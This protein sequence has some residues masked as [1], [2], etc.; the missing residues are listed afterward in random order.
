ME[1]AIKLITLLAKNTDSYPIRRILPILED[2]CMGHKATQKKIHL[3]MNHQIAYNY[4]SE[5]GTKVRHSSIGKF[6]A[7]EFSTR[8]LVYDKYTKIELATILLKAA[9]IILRKDFKVSTK[10]GL[11]LAQVYRRGVGGSTCMTGA[12]SK[13]FMQLLIKNPRHV[14]VII[15]GASNF[16]PCRALLWKTK[17]KT[18]ILDRVYPGFDTCS[19]ALRLYALKQNWAI[20]KSFDPLELYYE[21]GLSNNKEENISLL[22]PKGVTL[23]RYM[24]PEFYVPYL[25]TFTYGREIKV[26]KRSRLLLSNYYRERPAKKPSEYAFISASGG[27]KRLL[28]SIEY[29]PPVA[30]SE[31]V[32]EP[33]QEY[34]LLNSCRRQQISNRDMGI[35]TYSYSRVELS[36]AALSMSDIR[37]TSRSQL[38]IMLVMRWSLDCNCSK[39]REY[40]ARAIRLQSEFSEVL[41]IVREIS[42]NIDWYRLILAPTFLNHH[43]TRSQETIPEGEAARNLHIE[44]SGIYPPINPEVD[45]SYAHSTLSATVDRMRVHR[46][47]TTLENLYSIL[48]MSWSFNCTCSRCENLKQHAVEVISRYPNILAIIEDSDINWRRVG[49]IHPS[50]VNTVIAASTSGVSRNE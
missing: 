15:F 47:D 41:S 42:A 48:S 27:F 29:P 4:I 39:C 50:L 45:N 32:P 5:K 14:K 40:R 21:I 22:L 34:C 1:E 13:Y 35:H 26:N 2:I 28:P 3:S 11:A 31:S 33:V 44:R 12:D 10:S 16:A 8:D 20:R 24:A 23:S 7:K 36:L 25:D 6:V 49:I 37:I 17:H 19:M 18:L 30:I 43:I 46:E 9:S 38:N